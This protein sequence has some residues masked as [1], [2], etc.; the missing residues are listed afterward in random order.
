MP[1]TNYGNLEKIH[2]GKRTIVYRARRTS[3]GRRVV[4]KTLRGP[5]PPPEQ[6]T[7]F[8]RELDTTRG[9]NGPGAIEVLAFDTLGDTVAIVLED[10]GGT[11]LATSWA[12]RKPS[13]E[14]QLRLAARIVDA[15]AHVHERNVVH[16]D[17]N[18]SNVVWND[19]T[20]EVKLIDFG[21]SA[22]RSRSNVA[23]SGTNAIEGTLSYI[24]PEQTG[25]MNR[26]LDYRADFYSLGA[27]LYELLTGRTPFSATDPLE[28]V[29]AHIARV[30]V[31]PHEIAPD[32]PR[33][34]SDVVMK[35]LAK[36]AEDR[37]QSAFGVRADLLECADQL[38]RTGQVTPFPLARYDVVERLQIP[39]KLYGRD[40]ETKALRG[41][42][43]RVADGA[44]EMVVVTGYSGIGK[45]SLVHEIHPAITAGGGHLVSG[46]FDQLERNVPYA[47]LIQ[48]LS[49]LLRQ[50][51]GESDAEVARWR[52][53]LVEAVGA[54]GR[55]LTDVVP[56]LEHLIGPQP[57]VEALPPVEAENRFHFAFRAFVRALASAEHP[58]V[59]FL[60]DLQWA[61]LPSIKLLERL[62]ADDETTHLLIL[63]AYR[64]N[65]VSA[66]HPLQL[67]LESIARKRALSTIVLAPLTRDDVR[68]LV[69]DALHRRAPET[70][71]LADA[72]FAK[73][74]GNPFFVTQ[75]LE[76]LHESRLLKLDLEAGRWRWDVADIQ[77][78]GVSDDVVAFMAQKIRRLGPEAQASLQLAACIG[79]TFDLA[80][81]AVV[82]KRTPEEAAAGLAEAVV[83]GLVLALDETSST[84]AETAR[85]AFLHDRV[86]QAAYSTMDDARRAEL[87]VEI[88]RLL[89]AHGSPAEVDERLF[90]IVD[91]LDRGLPLITSRDERDRVA[92]LNLRAG[93]RAKQSAAY[94]PALAYLSA[95]MR[96]TDG[97]SWA[98]R[99]DRTL[100]LYVEAAEAA[101]LGGDYARMDTAIETVTAN[102]RT[103][104]DR[105]R[106]LAVRVNAKSAK[107]DLVGALTTGLEAL[108][109]LGIELPERPNQVSVV[110]ELVRTKL[111][112]AGK[113]TDRLA[114]LPIMSD[115]TGRTAMKLMLSL[116]SAA[117]YAV[118]LL[119]PLLAFRMVTTTVKRGL[120]P[121]S[122]Y[123]MAVYGLV[124]C[125]L[126]EIDA[127]YAYGKL[128]LRF[129][130]RADDRRAQNRARHVFNAHIRF[131]KEPF[132]LS[133][134]E[135]RDVFQ[136]GV[137]NGDL[138]YGAFGAFM[139]CTLRLLAGDDLAELGVE[140][141]RYATA[142][143]SIGQ[144]TSGITHA[145]NRQ[146]I[147][148][149][150][151]E[152]ADPTILAG[153]AYDAARMRPAHERAKDLTNLFVSYCAETMLGVFFGRPDR[154]HAAAQANRAYMD[155][156]ASTA[157][158]PV[159]VFHAALAELGVATEL[160]IV[161]RQVAI[162]RARRGL[163]DLRRWAKHC[164]ANVEH[165]VLLVEA[166]LARVLGD[167]TAAMNAYDG[168]IRAAQASA[169][170]GDEALANELAGRFHLARGS[171]A[172]ARAYLQQALWVYRRWGATGKARALEAEHGELARTTDPT[173]AVGLTTTSTSESRSESLDLDS[174]MKASQAISG[175]IELPRVLRRLITIAVEN[176]GATRGLLILD[177]DGTWLV[178]AEL[179]AQGEEPIVAQGTPLGE[180]TNVARSVVA[181]VV[182][183]RE[184]LVLDDASRLEP[185]A[186]DPYIVARKPKSVLCAPLLN[187]GRLQG[188]L[189]LENDVAA[190]AFTAGRIEVLR[191]LSAQAA[192]SLENAGLYTHLEK[193]LKAQIRLTE[194]HR[195]FVPN[196]FLQ[197]LGRAS[198][199]DV[200]LGDCVEKEMSV[201]FS[202]I[203]G[204][205]PLVEGMSPELNIR[206]INT[207]LSYMEPEILRHGGFVEGYIG[208]A[209]MALFDGAADGAVRA[210]VDMLNALAKLNESRAAAGEAPVE[211]GIGVN[212]GL[213][214]MGTIGGS[215]RIKCGVIGDSVNLAS[216][217][218]TLTKVYRVPLIVSDATVARLSHPSSF[219]LREI[220]RVRVVGRA[221]PVRLHEVYD[222]DPPALR[223]AKR[224]AEDDWNDALSRYYAGD[225]RGAMASLTECESV[226][227]GDTVVA[228]RLARCRR[229]LE[230]DPGPA[231]TGVETL[232]EK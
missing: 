4:L 189:Y 218:E 18:P 63:G 163:R 177:H 164:P 58:L 89:L 51:L 179:A 52:A 6:A 205:T 80:T 16:K 215:A 208:D 121:E 93:M 67:A 137:A 98:R 56:E 69:A 110:R 196:E 136:V 21:I 22:R 147:A 184:A 12:A 222:A 118:P 214:T 92:D 24:A 48:A 2:E 34:V 111:T 194:A 223:D 151:G 123:G 231:W 166:E 25:R 33:A 119:L 38:A 180:G 125:S 128:A 139:S 29:H 88:G 212:T 107:N 230:V 27:T 213:L 126:N 116:I 178:D 35:L 120:A 188:L 144:E 55:V 11:S 14:G 74:G 165:R 103:P 3:D 154:A 108:R 155:G 9:A 203:R 228:R 28:L 143:R 219:C 39:Q 20:G 70:A 199:V 200:E 209:I 232:D 148:N 140:T 183:T 122:S 44:F 23:L 97:S 77:T 60:D 1:S 61:D 142:I 5:Y 84:T 40:A 141:E 7:R 159:F 17:V 100:A 83:H 206:F 221:A 64:E 158:V 124:L 207:Y 161:E 195:R 76:G 156:G 112:L 86:Q 82:Q 43:D 106:V 79:A 99:Y 181:Y 145:I 175:E 197:N 96:L 149:L 68:S 170:T 15:L 204:F 114:A 162:L 66:A 191:L 167:D 225:F 227:P 57:P 160:S 46:K 201:L 150:V 19:A 85:F 135:L 132:R 30:P 50:V 36:N 101:Y 53:R 186:S 193:A 157:Y 45:T 104:L 174:V 91:H 47:S 117:Y 95:A 109:L 10:F 78:Y 182:R 210:G 187:Q 211:V 226:L 220:D 71:S 198:I 217:V 102:A 32:V 81:L 224:L 146:V 54:Q 127:G 73:T 49:Q 134:A 31:P 59:L 41:A 202:D 129:A 90:E 87:D 94:Q 192:I 185:F 75:L 152:V 13:L 65:E 113:S 173:T 153:P 115:E 26:A 172:V 72:C 171:R 8:R 131:W 42:F 169:A 190:G 216:R 168:A 176:A 37:Y 62:A 130:E 138:E 229:F 133:A 105:A